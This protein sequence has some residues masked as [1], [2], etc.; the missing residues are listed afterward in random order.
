MV[1]VEITHLGR[2]GDGVATIEGNE[3]F[4]PFTLPGETVQVSGAGKRLALETVAIP[5]PERAEPQCRHFGTCGGCQLQHLSAK[6]YRDWKSGLLIETLSGAGIDFLP[7]EMVE[8]PAASRRKAVFNAARVGGKLALGFAERASDRIV[9]LRACPVLLPALSDFLGPL[10]EFASSLP[11]GRKPIRMAVLHSK[12]GFDVSLSG[13]LKLAPAMRNAL[14]HRATDLGF[15]RLSLNGEILI[16]VQKPV[17]LMD[18][19]T[20]IPPPGAF[21]QAVEAAEHTMAELVAQHLSSCRSVADLY[22]G[23]GT[24]ALRL[25]RSSTVLAVEENS[26][27]V[28]ALDRAWRGTGGK[29]KQLRT[30]VRNLERRPMS[31]QELKKT[32]GVVFDPPRAGAEIQARQLAKSRVSRIAAVSCNPVT[33]ARD[34]DILIDGGYRLVRIIPIDQFRFTPHLEVVA[35]LER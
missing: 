33:L 5:S 12:A 34:L 26:D 14:T 6:A 8:F 11:I 21:V 35:L 18:N 24:F 25:A 29:L 10:R 1:E 32:D 2:Q 7:D 30:E 27:A 16:E 4:V 15:A 23:I 9:D 20:V 22:C 28:V 19:V 13:A 17:L 3:V 31:F